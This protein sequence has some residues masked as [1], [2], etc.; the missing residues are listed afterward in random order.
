MDNVP[1]KNIGLTSLGYGT[2]R[3]CT[4]PMVKLRSCRRAH[5]SEGKILLILQMRQ[6]LGRS[7][8]HGS[9]EA[10]CRARRC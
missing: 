7:C 9:I 10:V 6:H 1:R 3:A 4:V 5:N 8:R 2:L